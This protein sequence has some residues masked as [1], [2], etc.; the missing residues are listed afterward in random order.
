MILHLNLLSLRIFYV[1]A[2][3]Y[4]ILF[5]R[6]CI[7][8]RLLVDL[9]SCR[10]DHW[11]RYF[12]PHA[13]LISFIEVFNLFSEILNT[14]LRLLHSSFLDSE[15]S[16]ILFLFITILFSLRFKFIFKTLYDLLIFFIFLIN[17]LIL[18]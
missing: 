18:L 5:R 3:F 10:S 6:L 4:D 11:F 7:D 14:F 12:L 9:R 15:I 13:N 17:L 8:I 16:L 1:L 2:Y